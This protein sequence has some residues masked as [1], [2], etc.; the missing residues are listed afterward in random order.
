[1]PSRAPSWPWSAP[2]GMS[3]SGLAITLGLKFCPM[4]VQYT[5]VD[6]E[7]HARLVVGQFWRIFLGFAPEFFA[8]LRGK[9]GPGTAPNLPPP[10]RCGANSKLYCGGGGS[11]AGERADRCLER[12]RGSDGPHFVPMPI[13]DVASKLCGERLVGAGDEPRKKIVEYPLG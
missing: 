7:K 4:F 11:L 12:W 2:Y 9:W 8:F 13:A 6:T 5:G 3:N 10:D 1:M